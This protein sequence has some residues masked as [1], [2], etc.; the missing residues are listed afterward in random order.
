MTETPRVRLVT[1]TPEWAKRLLK[2]NEG[3]RK[4]RP[5]HSRFIGEEISNGRG[6][7]TTDA[8]GIRTNGHI[9]NGRHR[10]EAIVESGISMEVI[11]LEGITDA[12]FKV[13][14][15]GIKRSISDALGISPKLAA[16]CV[17][18]HALLNPTQQQKRAS[19]STVTDIAQWWSPT[20]QRLI[21]I[22]QAN[23]KGLSNAAFRIGAGLRLESQT[24]AALGEHIVQQW[25]ALL[26]LDV[27]GLN[28]S[29]GVLYNRFNKTPGHAAWADR[30]M[31]CALAWRCFDPDP[32]LRDIRPK[33]QSQDSL[34]TEVRQAL[35]TLRDHG[36][37][38]EV[39]RTAAVNPFMPTRAGKGSR[40]KKADRVPA[41]VSAHV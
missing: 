12:A 39:K 40:P 9:G 33:L 32:K 22:A 20:H 38:A 26:S 15:T 24:D 10:L 11:L 8:I 17:L 1:M 35:T 37:P 41:Q 2:N 34:L 25:K 31:A 5:S 19:V 18:I 27:G 14:D 16:D 6:E 28:R 30:L 36:I 4:W 3:N 21:D 29:V 13:I 23:P 7:L